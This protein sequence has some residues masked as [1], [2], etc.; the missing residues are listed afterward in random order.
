MQQFYD[1]LLE[2]QFWPR[3]QLVD[4]QRSQLEQLLRHARANVPF[5][6]T[7]LD[8]VFARDGSVDW[9]KWEQI[10]I[11][12]RSDLVE[13]RGAMQARVL[14]PGHGPVGRSSSSGSTGTPVTVSIT[15]LA[16]LASDVTR[17]RAHRWHG[18]DWSAVVCA[19]FGDNPERS[20]WPD[21]TAMGPWGPPWIDEARRGQSFEINRLAPSAEL[22]EFL[23]RKGP[24]YYSSAPKPAHALALESE[25]LHLPLK[26]DAILT[27]GEGVSDADRQQVRRVFGAEIIE[28]YSSK[29]GMQMAHPCP[30]GRLH[31]NA[32]A[33]LVEIVDGSGRHCP[34]GAVGRVVITPF[35][36]TA[37]PLIRYEQGDLAI[38]GG[39]CTCGRSLPTISSI[40]GRLTHMFIHPNG[41]RVAEKL[42]DRYRE[43][44]GA[45]AWQIAQV[46]PTNFEIRYVPEDLEF[47]GNEAAAAQAIRD[48]YFVDASVSFRRVSEIPLRPGGKY[49]E[50]VNEWHQERVAQ[51][52]SMGMQASPS[53]S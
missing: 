2:S 35:F 3:Q 24:R 10:P 53:R 21:G 26:L 28:H 44:L 52:S 17:W 45:L 37:Q 14:P 47:V 40:V 6:E 18:L 13:H 36:Q 16:K 29:E 34:A 39:S 12:K 8:P 42:P 30:D 27:H 38:A 32:E 43:G 9:D 25:R 19:R 7:R 20:S 5:Y 15:R 49:V 4:Y 41:R 1:M 22:L 23:K 48:V 11:V 50:Y 33:V 46:G 31:V 51:S